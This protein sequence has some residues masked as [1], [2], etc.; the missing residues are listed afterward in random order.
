MLFRSNGKV[1]EH[2]RYV[3]EMQRKK[4]RGMNEEEVGSHLKP[5]SHI[6]QDKVDKFT[7]PFNATITQS[8]E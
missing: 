7:T 6:Q 3:I 4:G 8:C 1:Q 5:G 2:W